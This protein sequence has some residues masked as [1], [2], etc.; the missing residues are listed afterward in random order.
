LH[1]GANGDA[2]STERD[3]AEKDASSD[4]RGSFVP[5]ARY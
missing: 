4:V 5:A 2:R 3:E 1:F